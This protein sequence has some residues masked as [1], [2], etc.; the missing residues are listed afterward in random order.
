MKRARVVALDFDGVLHKYDGDVRKMNEPVEGALAAVEKLYQRGCQVVVLTARPARVVQKWLGEYGFPPMS[1]T[2]VKVP[3]IGVIVDDRAITFNGDWNGLVDR[4]VEF[5][6]YWK[7]Q[8]DV[9][10]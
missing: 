9:K 5:Q 7:G 4:I 3:S 1:V 2:N 10:E 6:P 8:E